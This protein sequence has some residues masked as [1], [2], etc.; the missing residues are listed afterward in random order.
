VRGLLSDAWGLRANLAF[1][2]AVYV[3][4]AVHLGADLLT[5][6]HRLAGVPNLPVRPLH[7]PP[8]P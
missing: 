4:L 1:P 3:A 8:G 6:D 2:D 5:D 7:L